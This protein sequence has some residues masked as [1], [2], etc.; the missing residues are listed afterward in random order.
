MHFHMSNVDTAAACSVKMKHHNLGSREQTSNKGLVPTC[1]I[2][3]RIYFRYPGAM[4]TPPF[5][6]SRPR[7]RDPIE[8]LVDRGDRLVDDLHPSDRRAQ[9]HQ[10]AGI[11]TSL[12]S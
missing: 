5:S 10:P 9:A 7:C 6:E 12:V 2:A 4:I 11:H 1:S 8:F 3:T